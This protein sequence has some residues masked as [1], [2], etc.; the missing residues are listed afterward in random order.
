MFLHRKKK[1]GLYKKIQSMYEI[2]SSNLTTKERKKRD[3]NLKKEK[4]REARMED[5]R[6]V[7]LSL[8]DSNI[9]NKGRVILREAKNTWAIG[10]KLG[11]RVR[12]NEEDVI[13]DIVRAEYQ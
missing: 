3:K 11:L 6:I 4:E 10:K 13:E 1:K 12:D 2:Q 7:N 8:S 5:E 9:S